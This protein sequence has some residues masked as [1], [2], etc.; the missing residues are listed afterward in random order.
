M[1]ELQ[2][3]GEEAYERR[4]AITPVSVDA[5]TRQAIEQTIEML[6]A[7]QLRMAE[8]LPVMGGASVGQKAVLLYF[9]INENQQLAAPGTN[10]RMTKCRA[11]IC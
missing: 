1:T 7:G 4:E 10:F 11:E 3:L 6:D 5:L 8:R 9:R 2:R